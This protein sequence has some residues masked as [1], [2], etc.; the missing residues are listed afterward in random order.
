MLFLIDPRPYEAA[1]QQVQAQLAHDQALL[2]QAQVD[3]ARYE[4]LE[5]E[6]SIAT[7]TEQDQAYVVERTKPRCRSTRPM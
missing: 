6:N 7:Q 1:L 2:A 5:R 4:K 3:L